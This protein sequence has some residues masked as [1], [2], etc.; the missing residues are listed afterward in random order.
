MRYLQPLRPARNRITEGLGERRFQGASAAA[1]LHS[2]LRLWRSALSRLLSS[3]EDEAARRKERSLTSLPGRCGGVAP[4][5][6]RDGEREK[7]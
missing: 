1:R 2:R 7:T 5:L 6:F 4:T 3:G